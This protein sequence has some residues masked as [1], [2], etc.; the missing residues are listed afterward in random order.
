MPQSIYDFTGKELRLLT[1][2]E[3]SHRDCHECAQSLCDTCSGPSDLPKA[4]RGAN[5]PRN[6]SINQE[7][8]DCLS[9]DLLTKAVICCGRY[10]GKEEYE[11]G[12]ADEYF[13]ENPESGS[14]CLITICPYLDIA[15][16]QSPCKIHT[17]RP[18]RAVDFNC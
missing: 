8:T 9:C 7:R 4:I 11:D 1:S 10:C 15:H 18:Q 16:P 5:F 12:R 14:I 13:I 3:L 2:E 6:F 17:K